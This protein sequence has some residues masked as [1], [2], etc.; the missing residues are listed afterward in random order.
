MVKRAK[1]P[2]IALGDFGG[3]DRAGVATL[4][5]D[6]RDTPP[7]RVASNVCTTHARARYTHATPHRTRRT[8]RTDED[9]DDDDDVASDVGAGEG[10]DERETRE[11]CAKWMRGGDRRC[12]VVRLWLCAG[13][14]RVRRR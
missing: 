13:K 4:A 11:R 10:V 5:H 14:A 9:N 2:I 6:T 8:R 12:V 1:P 7:P 3:G